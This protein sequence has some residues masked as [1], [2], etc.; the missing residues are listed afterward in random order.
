[1]YLIT[2]M[3]LFHTVVENDM[4]RGKNIL[5]VTITWDMRDPIP[6][7]DYGTDTFIYL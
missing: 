6:F 1:M 4:H 3:P 2:N 5:H 7:A